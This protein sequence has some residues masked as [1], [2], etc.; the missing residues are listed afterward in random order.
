MLFQFYRKKPLAECF[1]HRKKFPMSEF[2]L[3]AGNLK[4]CLDDSHRAQPR[5]SELTV[6]RTLLGEVVLCP[7]CLKSFSNADL[8]EGRLTVEHIV[9]SGGGGDNLTLTCR[10]CNNTTGSKLDAQLLKRI[11]HEEDFHQSGGPI[12]TRLSVGG[13]AQ[14]AH[15]F[16]EESDDGTPLIKIVG[17]PEHTNPALLQKLLEALENLSSTNEEIKIDY[18]LGYVHVLSQTALLRSA[19]LAMFRNFGYSYILHPTLEPVRQQIWHP[20]VETSEGTQVRVPQLLEGIL[21][22]N[23]VAELNSAQVGW[24]SISGSKP[25]F[26]AAIRPSTA[27][28]FGFIVP[29][30]KPDET[31]EEFCA[32][33]LRK[34]EENTP[35]KMNFTAALFDRRPDSILSVST[36]HFV[37]E[38]RRFGSG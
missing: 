3:L 10:V 14:N 12:R 37:R 38:H 1:V 26:F 11:R 13:G 22:S 31:Q 9:P 4:A 5:T 15:L 7:L 20:F 36:C 33:L 6:D 18:N 8:N 16:V 17:L 27:L 24:M 29:M 34:S 28:P 19:Y 2:D 32:R 25:G 21:A 23:R 30:P 35:T